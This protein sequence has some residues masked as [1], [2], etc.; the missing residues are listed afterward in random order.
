[1]PGVKVSPSSNCR[2]GK[3]VKKEKADQHAP[4]AATYRSRCGQVNR[5]VQLDS[6][7]FV[8]GNDNDIFH[9]NQKILLHFGLQKQ[10]QK[11]FV[12]TGPIY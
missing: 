10:Q 3:R 2:S 9:L 1:M 5:L 11:L 7:F 8:F 6:V 4:E 12:F